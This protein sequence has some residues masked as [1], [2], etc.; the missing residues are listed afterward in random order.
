M[1]TENSST[2]LCVYENRDR[3]QK[4]RE[5]MASVSERTTQINGM[6]KKKTRTKRKNETYTIYIL[7]MLIY[8]LVLRQYATLNIPQNRIV[9]GRMN[10]VVR[11][12]HPVHP[13]RTPNR[14]RN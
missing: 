3:K 6:R 10:D 14:T 5:G 7:S 12:P 8:G 1:R 11:L 13:S 4:P 2:T 9:R